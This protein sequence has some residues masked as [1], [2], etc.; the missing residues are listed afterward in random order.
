MPI[1][2]LSSTPPL[3]GSWSRTETS[4]A[5]AFPIPLEDLHRG[6]LAR[7]VGAEEGEDLSPID[8][9][10][11]AADRLHVPVGL[12]E[13]SDVDHALGH[14]ELHTTP[15]DS[16]RLP[17]GEPRLLRRGTS[18][19]GLRR[20]ASTGRPASRLAPPGSRSSPVSG[21][22]IRMPRSA[23]HRSSAFSDSCARN[24]SLPSTPPPSTSTADVIRSLVSIMRC[25]A[26]RS[27][28]SRARSSSSSA[29][30]SSRVKSRSSRHA[31]LQDR[32]QLAE[33]PYAG[34]GMVG[35]PVAPV[36][37]HGEHPERGR[38]V[39]VELRVVADVRGVRRVHARAFQREPV[40]AF[41]RLLD[42]LDPRD[43]ADGEGLDQLVDAR[44]SPRA[45]PRSSTRCR[46]GA[47]PPATPR[48]S[49]ARHRTRRS[50]PSA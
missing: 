48:S 13:S 5:V 28:G 6:R 20:A 22:R 40:D 25:L 10:V 14:G 7:A 46:G 33:V 35:E 16:K 1:L 2:R 27:R 4:P 41:V 11:D 19:L 34:P 8:V 31:G 44:T 29:F 30:A 49:A 32:R 12:V 38:R 3:A 39:D 18:P 24:Q 21:S 47:R 37:E 17:A 26:S 23:S 42:A 36:D 15:R 9:E 43:H 45:T 50:S